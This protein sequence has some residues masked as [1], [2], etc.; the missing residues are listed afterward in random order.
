VFLGDDSLALS[1]IDE[2]RTRTRNVHFLRCHEHQLAPTVVRHVVAQAI[3]DRTAT[4]YNFTLLGDDG[5]SD[6]VID[7]LRELGFTRVGERW[8]KL[9]L[10]ACGTPSEVLAMVESIRKDHGEHGGLLDRLCESCLRVARSGAEANELREVERL[11]FPARLVDERLCNFIV[12]IRPRWAKE[13]FDA[14][15]ASEDLLPSDESIAL[16]CENV[17]YRS[18]HVPIVT[19]PGYVL[20]YVT[21]DKGSREVRQVRA[22]SAVDEVVKDVPK[23]LFRRFQRLGVYSWRDVL[24]VARNDDARSILAFRFS[25]TELFDRGVQRKGLDDIIFRHEGTVPP[26]SMPYGISPSCFRELYSHCMS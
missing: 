19:A 18:G 17:Y 26:L 24:G 12:P 6:V 2:P 8:S 10:R 9:S 21:A 16:R 7:A 15:L 13:L 25:A 22:C 14:P 5:A 23:A 3:G 11:L 1:I 20:W 4:E